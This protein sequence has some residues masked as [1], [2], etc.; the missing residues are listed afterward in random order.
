MKPVFSPTRLFIS[1]FVLLLAV[2]IIVLLGISGNRSGKPEAVIELTERELA[3]L[4]TYETNDENS[5]LSL[6]LDWRIIP[7]IKDDNYSFM[8]WGSP[9]WLNEQ[10]L[11]ELGFTIDTFTCPDKDSKKIKSPLPRDAF[12]VLEYDGNAYQEALKRSEMN[13]KKAEA[14]LRANTED[15]GL[16]NNFKEA[17]TSVEDE[18]SKESRL[19]AIDAGLDA[20]K[21]RERYADRSKYIVLPGIVDLMCSYD[22]NKSEIMGNITDIRIDRINVPLTHRNVFDSILAQDKYSKDEQTGFSNKFNYRARG[23]KSPRYKVE[24]AYGSRFEPWI[25]RVEKLVK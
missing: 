9:V 10:K 6:R 1:G 14:A 16:Q 15:K 21:L 25:Q 18:R 19:Y 7:E 8:R 22:K 12:I 23:K 2:N 11:L 13:L 5:G 24:L 3:F 20:A 17:Q 4:N